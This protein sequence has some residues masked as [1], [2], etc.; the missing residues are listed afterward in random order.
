MPTIRV[1]LFEGR[2]VEQ[3]RALAAALTEALPSLDPELEQRIRSIFRDTAVGGG[4]PSSDGA[5][6]RTASANKDKS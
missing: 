3:K 2:S 6:P 1:E 4:E 5:L